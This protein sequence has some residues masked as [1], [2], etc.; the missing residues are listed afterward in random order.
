MWRNPDLSLDM[1]CERVGSNKDYVSQ[2]FRQNANTTFS[3]YVN[4]LRVD[5]MAE[6][7][8]AHPF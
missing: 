6:E 3:D 8:K 2:C 7:L 1:L 4:R 5:Y